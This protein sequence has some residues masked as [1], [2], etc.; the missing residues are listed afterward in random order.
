MTKILQRIQ[1]LY[2]AYL[3]GT[4]GP[5]EL[6][7]LAQLVQQPEREVEVTVLLENLWTETDPAVPFFSADVSQ[8]LLDHIILQ[9]EPVKKRSLWRKLTAAVS[10]AAILVIISLAL[11]FYTAEKKLLVDH[12]GLRLSGDVLPGG[13]HATLTLGNGEKI[14]LD[15]VNEG[16]L[17][18]EGPVAISKSAK[19]ILVFNFS[20]GKTPAASH[21]MN[22]VTVPKGGQYQLILS[23]GTRV[24]LNSASALR[25]PSAFLSADRQVELQGEAY[26]EV[27]KVRKKPFKIQVQ[28]QQIE[29]L[30][31]HFNVK[32][33]AEEAPAKT[34]LLEG[35]LRLSTASQSRLLKPGEQGQFMESGRINVT[36]DVDLSLETAWKNG[37][38]KFD[39]AGL[40]E[41]MK[42]VS[43]WYNLDIHY[44]GKIPKKR[45]TGT[46][47]RNVKVSEFLNMFSYTGLKFEINGN[48]L[49]VL[50][51]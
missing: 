36:D 48:K 17:S 34:T 12:R 22:T 24:W 21:L 19:G 13:N 8:R 42:Q 5:D 3:G 40:E 32:A 7:E 43:R 9:K 10:A 37:L 45:F 38:F 49:T 20:K 39:D 11:F 31:T 14:H 25:F 29:V 26:F 30:G 46:V 16:L 4:A 27:A 44:E 6:N 15:H 47:P 1:H 35:S 41:V 23:D 50:H 18:Q 28:G 2:N 33:Y 51:P